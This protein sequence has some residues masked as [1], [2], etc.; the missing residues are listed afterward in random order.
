MFAYSETGDLITSHNTENSGQ[1]TVE[2]SNYTKKNTQQLISPFYQF[3]SSS[4]SALGIRLNLCHTQQCHSWKT[5][6]WKLA[7]VT[8]KITKQALSLKAQ[9]Y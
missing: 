5:G 7:S 6:S 3:Y 1:Q 8:G 2:S 4:V 9:I